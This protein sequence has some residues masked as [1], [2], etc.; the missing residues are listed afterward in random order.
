MSS[1][2]LYQLDPGRR[3]ELAT[4]PE[5]WTAEDE[6]I[7]AAH[8]A[9]LAEATK[10]G[11]VILA[12]RSQ[13]GVGPAIV[14]FEADSESDAQTFMEKDPFV[15]EGMFTGSLFNFSVALMRDQGEYGPNPWSR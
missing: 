13:D 11:I 3:A 5:A 4:E 12:G 1:R 15:S 10:D 6:Q 8:F 14:I 2:F 7:G 9:Y